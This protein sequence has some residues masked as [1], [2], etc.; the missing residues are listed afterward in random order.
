MD[1]T[2]LIKRNKSEKQRKA[3]S[4]YWKGRVRND[5]LDKWRKGEILCNTFGKDIDKEWIQLCGWILTDGSI[6]KKWGHIEIFQ[7][8]KN[9]IKEIERILGVLDL[10][11]SKYPSQDG[12]FKFYVKARDSKKIL[13]IL[14]LNP[15]KDTPKWLLGLGLQQILWFL[16]AVIDGDGSKTKY[17]TIIAGTEKRLKEFTE[18]FNRVGISCKVTQNKR[19]DWNLYIHQG[20]EN[21]IK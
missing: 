12:T 21:K 16:E 6:R 5:F 10:R 17:G 9:G 15:D 3:V 7:K 18:I 20:Y 4:K 14:C 13:E 11:Y 2:F 1:T 8:K 19:G